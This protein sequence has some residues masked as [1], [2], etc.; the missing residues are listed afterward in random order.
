MLEILETCGGAEKC[1]EVSRCKCW[2]A[3]HGQCDGYLE[4]ARVSFSSSMSKFNA[5]ANFGTLDTT[6]TSRMLF[7][8][9]I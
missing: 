3:D 8:T 5:N 4:T 2:F 9:I 1:R 7:V 6:T